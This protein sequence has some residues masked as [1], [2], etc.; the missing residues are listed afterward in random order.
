VEK[1]T[2]SFSLVLGLAVAILL[3]G[4]DL[5]A[6]VSLAV[7]WDVLVRESTAAAV[8]TPVESR[9][10]WEDGRIVTYTR[11][12]VDRAVA[13]DLAGSDGPWVR[14]LGGVVGTIGQVV[15]GEAVF[16]PEHASLVFVRSGAAG[17]FD[18]TAR[19]QGQFP[20]VSDPESAGSTRVVRSRTV[21]LLLPRPEKA[22]AARVTLASEI[23]H[24][25]R[26]DEAAQRIA[27]AWP[28]AHAR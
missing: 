14:T 24:G 23:L 8:V 28:G 10:V 25:L 2:S 27:D 1:G 11:V 22:H 19:G 20:V 16:V 17:T 15:D 7:A 18:V 26:V 12:R 3:V 9:A 13:G 6:S 4:R 21:G 5:R